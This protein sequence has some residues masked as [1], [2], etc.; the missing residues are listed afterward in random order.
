MQKLN[1]KLM[2]SKNTWHKESRAAGSPL[3]SCPAGNGRMPQ[4][5]EAASWAW[6]VLST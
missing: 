3:S 4:L 5:L 1:V 2:N 6:S